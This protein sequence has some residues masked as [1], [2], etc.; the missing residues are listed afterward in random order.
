MATKVTT[1]GQTT[2]TAKVR[3]TGQTTFVKKIV[4]GTPVR[5]VTQQGLTIVGLSDTRIINPLDKQIL[6]F[7]SSQQKFVNRDSATLVNL[8]LSGNVKSNLVPSQDSSFDL[9]DSAKKWKDLYLSG[10]TI[11]LGGLDIKD[12]AAEFSV[13]DS[14]GTPVNFNLSGSTGQIRGMFS[15]G[16]D[17][18]YNSSSGQF[19]FDVE[20]VYTKS[21]FDSDFNVALDSA[22]LEGVGLTYNNATNSLAIDSSELYSL[23][24]HDDF[25]DFVADEHVPHSNVLI[26]AGA[27]L[28][29]GGDIT[30]SRTLDVVGGKGIIANANDIQVDSANIRTMIDS[31]FTNMTTSIHILD[32]DSSSMPGNRITF[33]D[34]SDLKIYHNSTVTPSYLRGSYLVNNTSSLYINNDPKGLFGMYYG[35]DIAIQNFANDGYVVIKADD[36]TGDGVATYIAANGQTGE[37]SL[38]FYGSQRLI[39]KNHGVDVTGKLTA[40]S[41]TFTNINIPDNGIIKL[42][43]DSDL[44]IFHNGSHSVIQDAGTGSLLVQ[45]NNFTVQNAT[46]TENQITALSGGAVSLYHN[47]SAKLATTNTGVTV[48][49]TINADSG[50]FTNLTRAA[51]VDSGTYGTAALVPVITVNTSGF[52]DSIGTVSVAGVSSVAFDSATYNYTINTAD[53]GTF[54]KMIH[55]RKPGLAAGTHGSATKVPI[56]TIN[57]YGLVDSIA[58]ADVAGVSSTSFDSASGIFTINTADGSV[59]NTIIA[60][61]NFTNYRSRLALSA[62]DAGGDGSFSYNNGTGV[63]TYTGPSATETRAHMVAGTGVTYDSASGVISIGQPVSTTDNVT[64]ADA[65]FTNDVTFDSA[66]ALFFDKSFKVLKFGDNYQAQF[67]D[68]SDL[69][70]YHDGSNSIIE[71]AGTGML[72]VKAS[73]FRVTNANGSKIAAQFSDFTGPA[74]GAQ[75]FFDGTKRFE[76]KDSGVNIIGQLTADSGTFTNITAD[77]AV[78]TDLSGNTLNYTSVNTPLITGPATLTID[79]AAVGDNTGTLRILGNLTVEGTTTTINS[80]NLSVND[81]LIVIADSAPDSAGLNQAGILF[82]GSSIPANRPS[83]KYN[84]TQNRFAF[85]RNILADG[86]IG[87]VTGTVSDISNH[88]TTNLSEGSNLYFTDERVDD[89]INALLIGGTNI[90]VTYNDS[91]N[92]LRIDGVSGASGFNLSANDTDDLSEGTSNLYFTN[93]R[94]QSAAQAVSLDSAEAQAMIDSNLNNNI[95][96]GGDVTFDSAGAI[97]FDKSDKSL[98]IGENHIA[99]FG[100]NQDLEIKHTNGNSILKANNG[101]IFIQSNATNFG[102]HIGKLNAAETMAKFLPDSSVEL[103]HNNVKR[104]ETT[105]KGIDVAGRVSIP[106]GSQTQ[107][108]LV[109]GNDSDFFIYHSGQTVIANK[110]GSGPIKIQGKFGEQSIIANQDSSVEL[111]HNN[112][113]RIETTAYGATVTGT[114]NADSATITGFTR[115]GGLFSNGDIGNNQSAKGVYAGLSTAG[116]AQLSLVGDNTDVSPQIDFSHDVS[117]DYD[118]RLI[119]ENAGNRLSIKSHG[120]ETMANFN[121]DGA[122]EL[123]HDNVKKLE[124]TAYG[125]TVTGTVNADSATISG[126]VTLDSAGAVF[127]DKSDQSLNFG[128]NYKAKFGPVGGGGGL[129]VTH[130]GSFGFVDTNFV[131]IRNNGGTKV[132]AQFFPT[133]AQKLNYNGI[134]RFQTTDSGVAVTGQLTADSATVTN[135]TLSTGATINEFS[136]DGT[137]GGNS[138]TAAPTEAAVKTYVDNNAGLDS[139]DLSGGSFSSG[140][141]CRGLTIDGGTTKEANILF[142]VTTGRTNTTLSALLNLAMS[143][144]GSGEF[145]VTAKRGNDRQITKL[146]YVHDGTDVTATQYGDVMTGP[147]LATYD[148][149]VSGSNVVFQTANTSSTSTTFVVQYTLYDVG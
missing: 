70:I 52:I 42:G 78:I 113:K 1:T 134:T 120:N 67:G 55:T 104:L 30:S 135:L 76:T 37:A 93:A 116:D 125:A 28:T 41:S 92:T 124:T 105:S 127:F 44:K 90:T 122:V 99:K 63:F 40:D 84:H 102:V 106:D 86:F 66:G 39:T 130:T 97:L 129:S 96:F 24:K 31:S 18:S 60:D 8:T 12:S 119:L 83:F 81:K 140:I 73:Y 77:S 111:Y 89:R 56:V 137:L 34:D 74:G 43:N 133:E 101:P 128:N 142:T 62:T 3:T 11:H 147:S 68:S 123:H 27:G 108:N 79:P 85:N 5:S 110:N 115:T 87:N 35:R 95:T 117:I 103:Y 61:S 64:F 49:G 16:G 82:G 98:K 10:G 121:G 80:T 59:F 148:F 71:D 25:L 126:D 20:Q 6:V 15:A 48:T 136:T 145:T 38:W 100:E 36:G 17:L 53:G 75:L 19:S 7:D 4:I 118:V 132:A 22:A 88:S 112:V 14:I 107:N 143:V 72:D 50:T 51:T 109:L 138:N 9:G 69:K 131:Q 26:T 139:A 21:N 91:N 45:S 57:Q 144:Y 65:T 114:M 13:T 29:G 149:V 141:H 32:G 23:F 94:A 58:T 54:T 2:F 47:D 146:L 33:G 46:G